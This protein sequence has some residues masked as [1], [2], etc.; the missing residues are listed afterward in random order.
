MKIEWDAEKDAANLTKHGI[1]LA[2]AAR[3]D[4]AGGVHEADGRLDYGEERLV[5]YALMAARMYACV[6][7]YRAGVTRIISLRKANRREIRQHG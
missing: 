7:T 1:S 4:W 6:Y 2:E 5:L 3:M